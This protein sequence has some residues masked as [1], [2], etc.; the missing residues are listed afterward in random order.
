[1]KLISCH[2]E[3]FGKLHDYSMEFC[4]GANMICEENGW[5]KSTFAAFVRAMFYGL[6]GERKRS[7]VENERK[8]YKPWQGGVFGGQLVFEIHGKEYQVSRIFKDK[9]ANDEFELRDARTNLPSDAYGKKIGEEIFKINRESFMRTVFIGQNECETSSTDDINAKLGNFADNA[10]DL[11]RYEAA[12]ARLTEIVN[13]L[14]PSRVSGSIAKRREEI[15]RCERVMQGG[16]GIFESIDKYQNHLRAEEE[17]LESLKVRMREAG[18]E[19]T[20]VSK[21]QAVLARKSEWERLKGEVVEK[22]LECEERRRAFPKEVPSMEDVKHKIKECGEME[23]AY[24]RVQIHQLSE[25]ER[26]ELSALDTVFAEGAPT[27]EE[28][29]G[30][31][32]QER[33]SSVMKKWSERNSRKKALPSNKAAFAA[34]KV[35]VEAS[36]NTSMNASMKT[37]METSGAAGKSANADK[38]KRSSLWIAGIV[39]AIIGIIVAVAGHTAAGI[40]AVIVGVGLF[41]VG[42]ASGRN[43][44]KAAGGGEVAKP[45]GGEESMKTLKTQAD[46]ELENLQ[47]TIEEDEAFIAKSDKEVSD[48]LEAH[49]KAFEEELVSDSLQEIMEEAYA[50]KIKAEKYVVLKEKQANLE[51]A[52]MEF[53]TVGSAVATFLD[54]C[55]YVPSQRPSM[56]LEEIRDLAQR[57]QIAEKALRDANAR[58]GRFEAENDVAELVEMQADE[59][60]PSLEELNQRI[61]VLNDE[62]EKTHHSI[63]EYH[64]TLESLQREYDEWEECGT[65]LVELKERQAAEQKKYDYVFKAR[66]KL[67]LAK[68]AMTAKYAAPILH[69][70]G[71]Y[72]E[73]I[74]G[75]AADH[76]HVDANTTVTVD[77]F[78]KQRDTISLSSGYRDLV[79]I[80]LRMALV[81]AMYKEEVPFLVMDDP[82]ANLDDG[83]VAAGT[84]FVQKLAQRYQVIYF[85]CSKA[86]K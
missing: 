57:Y 69:G 24:E 2:V 22:R 30:R 73:M 60:L 31:M 8:R 18:E 55:G 67:G 1:M 47:R 43:G 44:A 50:F 36:M 63:N 49:G 20:R 27:N 5:G 78:G 62:M 75:G 45:S 71:K 17:L 51:K 16:K 9:E 7:V 79:G 56:Q 64:N 54:R 48:Y 35:S 86:R 23:K 21:R 77:E 39:L 46:L 76:F 3:N 52:M 41:L 33:I 61:Q 58:L 10:N 32:E 74:S 4:D 34:L 72:Y 81:E 11:N 12:N 70:F 83:K 40:C 65:R 13:A 26:V 59:S 53:K 29:N 28:R 85:T 25:A 80:C 14:T 84:E 82:F 19:Q 37:S 38:V 15:A 66:L 68:E 6:E 42:M